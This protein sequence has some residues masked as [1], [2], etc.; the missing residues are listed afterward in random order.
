MLMQVRYLVCPLKQKIHSL[1]SLYNLLDE[2]THFDDI[3]EFTECLRSQYYEL[4]VGLG[5]SEDTLERRKH[6]GCRD[7]RLLK[8]VLRAWLKGD[9]QKRTWRMLV[10]AIDKLYGE[11]AHEVAMEIAS[12]HPSGIIL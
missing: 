12:L 8:Q 1:Q 7:L 3:E 4:G 5:L 9:K 6:E 11:T 2:N 10:K